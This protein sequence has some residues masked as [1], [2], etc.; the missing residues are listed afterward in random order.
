[1]R[2]IKIGTT[3]VI[4][5]NLGDGAGKIIIADC[6][7]D[8][9]YSYYWGAMGKNTTIEKFLENITP[10][11]FSNKLI[12]TRNGR[13]I[14]I[15]ST[16]KEV[17]K[18]IRVELGLPWYKHLEFHKHMRQVLKEFQIICECQQSEVFF[19]EQ[20]DNYFITELDFSLI[21]DRYDQQRLE[22]EFK[23]ISEVW[24][25]IQKKDGPEIV[26]LE[27][28]LEKLKAK[29]HTLLSEETVPDILGMCITEPPEHSPWIPGVNC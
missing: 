22:K 29:L 9:N 7:Y 15:A 23:G 26:W 2:R 3:D 20:W 19:V 24:Y 4:L 18:H 11:Y 13:V 17:R 10:S 27:K 1:M 16:F 25:F 8:K 5:E 12:G 14:D 28:F 6:E 21:T